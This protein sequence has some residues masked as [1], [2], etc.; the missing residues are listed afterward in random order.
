MENWFA[1]Y[2]DVTTKWQEWDLFIFVVSCLWKQGRNFGIELMFSPFAIFLRNASSNVSQIPPRHCCRHN[3]MRCNVNLGLPW[4][5]ARYAWLGCCWIPQHYD[6]VNIFIATIV[7]TVQ[8]SPPSPKPRT[9]LEL[10][11]LEHFKPSVLFSL[12]ALNPL[13]SFSWFIIYKLTFSQFSTLL[14]YKKLWKTTVIFS[15]IQNTK[16]YFFLPWSFCIHGKV[17]GIR[18]DKAWPGLKDW[19]LKKPELKPKL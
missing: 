2:T 18:T 14:P 5:R 17:V 4:W 15:K 19:G 11:V 16:P 7:S 1:W 9:G 10:S 8:S 3:I 12:Q 6:G 13:Q